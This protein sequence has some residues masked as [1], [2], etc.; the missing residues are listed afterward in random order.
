MVF[1]NQHEFI[2]REPEA[3]LEWGWHFGRLVVLLLCPLNR[4]SAPGASYTAC[5]RVISL[6]LTDSSCRLH[7][8]PTSGHPKDYPQ[9]HL[10][11]K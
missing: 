1:R 11:Y 9:I 4:A 10:V 8:H 6:S 7:V 5:L 3:Y 2:D